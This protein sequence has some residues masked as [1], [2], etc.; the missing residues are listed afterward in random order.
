MGSF[1]SVLPGSGPGELNA[2]KGVAVDDTTGD[3]YVADSANDRVAEFSAAGSFIRSVGDMSDP[4][5]VAVNQFT[6]DVYVT[7][8]GNLR[9]DEFNE[10]G[11]FL[12]AW[13]AGVVASGPDK[14]S[15][16]AQQAVSVTATGGT[17]TLTFESKTTAAVASDAPAT[18]PG[19]VQKALESLL[20]A[21]NVGVTVTGSLDES[22]AY[23]VTFEGALANTDVPSMTAD[24]ASLVGAGASVTVA[25]VTVGD[26]AAEV[27][28]EGDTCQAGV[29][30]GTGGAFAS[31]FDGYIA[32]APAGSPDAGDVIVAD[33]GNSRVQEF[34]AT[35]EFVRAFG[36]DVN[37]TALENPDSTTA[38]RD[39]C[40]AVSGDL[41]QAGVP[42][43]EVGQFAAGAPTRVAVAASGAIYTVES[44][45]GFRVQEFTPADGGLSASVFAEPILSGGEPG[46]PPPT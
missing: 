14:V 40:T 19:S 38:E 27:C 7:D 21:G 33:P 29:S 30:A 32:V 24:G 6:G 34:T 39:L 3:V 44:S 5:G 11:S 18:G 4:Q 35:G 25:T 45:A 15:V 46:T 13:G 20:G 23:T 28:S 36:R 8:E 1:G 31:T 16:D 2:P 26:S 41:C 37:R 10:S 17:F 12:R 9:V 43:A 22:H 42:G